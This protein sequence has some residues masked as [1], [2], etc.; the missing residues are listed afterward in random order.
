VELTVCNVKAKIKLAYNVWMVLFPIMEYVLQDLIH[1]MTDFICL[2]AYALLV[3]RNM[4]TAMIARMDIVKNAVKHFYWRIINVSIN[5]QTDISI[6]IIHV[7]LAIVIVRLVMKL[8]S[9]VAHVWKGTYFIRI[10]VSAHVHLN[11]II[12]KVYV[13]NVLLIAINVS[14]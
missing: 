9:N 14:D 4:L 12:I 11:S 8:H 3:N 10:T 6:T 1:V 2:E 5:A 13:I 7:Y